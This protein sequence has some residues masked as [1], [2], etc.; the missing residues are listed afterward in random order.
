M[1]FAHHPSAARTREALEYRGL[2]E[3][4]FL[5]RKREQFFQAV[6]SAPADFV[7]RLAFR[8]LGAT[9]WY[10]PFNRPDEARRPRMLWL[11][12]GLHPLPFFAILVLVFTGVRQGLHPA[13]RVAPVAGESAQSRPA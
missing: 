5:D 8:F 9:L 4:A 13:Q 7:D 3:A 12:R 10:V 11:S 2:G 1:I 6:R